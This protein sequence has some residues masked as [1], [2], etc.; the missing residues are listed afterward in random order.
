MP[1]TLT[2]FLVRR[3]A[4]SYRVKHPADCTVTFQAELRSNGC[5]TVF[6]HGSNQVDCHGARFVKSSPSAFDQLRLVNLVMGTHSLHYSQGLWGKRLGIR[7]LRMSLLLEKTC[8]QMIDRR[9]IA[10]YRRP[11]PAAKDSRDLFVV[12]FTHVPTV[13]RPLASFARG[14]YR[15]K[16]ILVKP[17]PFTCRGQ[18]AQVAAPP[19]KFRSIRDACP[20]G[21]SVYVSDQLEQVRVSIHY[22][23]FKTAAKQLSVK[24]V[25]PVVPLRIDPVDVAHAPGEVSQRSMNQ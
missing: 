1:E 23:G 15:E 19:V 14:E 4:L 18:V 24:A 6:S 13:R 2:E 17:V 25:G 10:K 11:F 22:N 9:L 7:Y 8:L 3:Q 5:E 20:Y 21:I 16:E 12:F